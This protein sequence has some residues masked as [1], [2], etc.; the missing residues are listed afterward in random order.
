MRAGAREEAQAILDEDSRWCESIGKH[1]IG[2]IEAVAATK[3]PGEVVN[4]LT[5]CNAG[6]LAFV[7]FGSATAPIYEVPTPNPNPNPDLL[8]A[9]RRGDAGDAKLG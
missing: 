4:L 8:S 5:H 6:W 1:G 3:G 2:L 7:D 9:S